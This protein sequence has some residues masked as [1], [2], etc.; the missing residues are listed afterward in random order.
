MFTLKAPRT[1]LMQNSSFTLLA[2][3][4]YLGYFTSLRN[5]ILAILEALVLR[6][7]LGHAKE[8]GCR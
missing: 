1:R 8:D 7:P 3:L 2:L 6:P 4:M 5:A